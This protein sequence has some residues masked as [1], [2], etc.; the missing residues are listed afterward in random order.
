MNRLEE[1]KAAAA[2]V[3]IRY[4]GLQGAIETRNRLILEAT[5]EGMSQTE[6]A[7]LV[8]LSSQRINQLVYDSTPE[9]ENGTH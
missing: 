2:D 8:G 1:L 4:L 7:N 9:D 6:V 3:S 5:R